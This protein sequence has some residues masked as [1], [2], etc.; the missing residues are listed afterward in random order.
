M[1][2]DAE[3]VLDLRA[4]ALARPVVRVGEAAGRL[5]LLFTLGG[6][7]L[8]LEAAWLMGVTKLSTLAPL[9]GA[10]PPVRG[11]TVWQGELLTVL[12]IRA[13]LGI[14]TSALSDMTRLLVIGQ[15]R[16]RFGL[17]V[18]A[19][20]DVVDFAE[21]RILPAPDN[22]PARPYLVGVTADARLILDGERLLELFD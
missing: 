2:A 17:I 13:L 8:A 4:R 10:Q 6:E 21:A 9:P 18:D 12:D 7:Q 16:A 19:V 22:S 20:G 15:Q 5:V 3:S 11:V 14:P 1:P